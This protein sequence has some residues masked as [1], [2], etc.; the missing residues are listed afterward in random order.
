MKSIQEYTDFPKKYTGCNVEWA[1]EFRP[2]VNQLA[3]ES[4]A[5]L[6]GTSSP[7]DPLLEKSILE[8]SI[9]DF[10][11]IMAHVML[12]VLLYTG[13]RDVLHIKSALA[14]IVQDIHN[15]EPSTCSSSE[16]SAGIQ[17][18]KQQGRMNNPF[19]QNF[20]EFQR[21]PVEKLNP[22]VTEQ[23]DGLEDHLRK[24][25]RD[26]VQECIQEVLTA[27]RKVSDV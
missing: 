7:D 24:Y 18:K 16:T 8:F 4:I 17:T 13:W 12:R 15:P 27:G 3:R 10:S 20:A 26:V 14:D 19:P 11:M 25:V 5:Q 21:Q 2:V 23:V 6:S 22:N 1:E 9:K